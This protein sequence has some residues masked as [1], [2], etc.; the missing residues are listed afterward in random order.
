MIDKGSTPH[1][2]GGRKT[3]LPPKVIPGFIG[4]HQHCKS[5]LPLTDKGPAERSYV[6][7][8]CTAHIK[9]KPHSLPSDLDT[10]CGVED[11]SMPPLMSHE[12]SLRVISPPQGEEYLGRVVQA[13][14]ALQSLT[15]E[16]Y[17]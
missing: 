4:T 15:D 9:V 7:M 10:M 3:H 6:R 16:V 17:A 11:T 8:S 12:P 2:D 14:R 1:T 5:L 13:S